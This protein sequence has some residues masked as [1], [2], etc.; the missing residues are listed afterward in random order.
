MKAPKRVD[1]PVVM[2][3]SWTHCGDHFTMYTNIESL[4]STLETNRMLHVNYT[5]LKK[6][7]GLPWWRSG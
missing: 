3:V 1:H 4:C 2:D 5:S 7:E 6:K